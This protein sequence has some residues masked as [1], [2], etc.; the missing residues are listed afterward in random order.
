MSGVDTRPTP[1][2]AR[3]AVLGALVVVVAS[4]L[5][6]T[7]AGAITVPGF[8]LIVIGVRTGRRMTITVGTVF[9]LAGTLA[10]GVFEAP[11]ASVVVAAIGTVLAWDMGRLAIDMGHQLGTVPTGVRSATVHAVGTTLVGAISAGVGYGV[12]RGTTSGQP[13]FA[14]VFLLISVVLLVYVME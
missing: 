5:G 7:T 6:S 10:A 14:V 2:A 12:Y 13:A 4:F 9:L 8:V 3:F 1:A 11:P